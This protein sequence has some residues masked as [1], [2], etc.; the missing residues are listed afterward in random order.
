MLVPIG[1]IF[2]ITRVV[3]T[4]P[5][6]DV[7]NYDFDQSFKTVDVP[8]EPGDRV[9]SLAVDAA[10]TVHGNPS[11]LQEASEPLAP[12]APPAPPAAEPEDDEPEA[13]SPTAEAPEDEAEDE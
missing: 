2:P 9:E 5:N 11:L 1:R 8:C 13:E 6:G 7:V 4:S 10:G 3:V 12:P